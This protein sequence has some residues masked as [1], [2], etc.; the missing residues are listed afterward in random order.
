MQP[1]RL[2]A[3]NCFSCVVHFYTLRGGCDLNGIK[4]ISHTH[5]T[6]KAPSMYACCYEINAK[7]CSACIKLF[8]L[9]I[10]YDALANT[11][12]ICRYLYMFILICATDIFF[13]C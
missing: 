8:S 1:K 11:H 5:A 4:H 7:M 13:F 12:I 9:K 3:L 6:Y 10:C 2:N